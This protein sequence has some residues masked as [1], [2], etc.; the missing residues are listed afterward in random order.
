MKTIT[1]TISLITI[2]ID[3]HTI[4]NYTLYLSYCQ[5][6]FR[7]LSFFVSV[8]VNDTVIKRRFYH[9]DT[10]L[11]KSFNNYFIH[12]GNERS[13]WEFKKAYQDYS[14]HHAYGPTNCGHTYSM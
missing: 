10:Y 8:I 3:N 13:F 12:Y 1:P 2:I 5:D 4:L 6:I 14:L 9:G 11:V 7:N